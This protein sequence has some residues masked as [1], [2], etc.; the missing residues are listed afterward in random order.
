M[1]SIRCSYTNTTKEYLKVTFALYTQ[2][3]TYYMTQL[4][5]RESYRAPLALHNKKLHNT[6]S[7]NNEIL[8]T[9][10]ITAQES[11]DFD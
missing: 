5:A 6:K 10:S 4:S 11:L 9:S 2:N 1:Q 7:E 8:P 3:I